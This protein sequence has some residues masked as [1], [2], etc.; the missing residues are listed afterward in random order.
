[1]A[2]LNTKIDEKVSRLD[3]N[4]DA[5]LR[6]LSSQSGPSVAEREAQLD[7]LL[8]L[9]LKHS[10]EEVEAKYDASVD[11]YLDTITQM[12]KVHDDLVAAINELIKHTHVRHEK[13]IQRLE[14][15]IKKKDEMN[16]I[17]QQVL[18]KLL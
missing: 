4:L 1:M 6:S 16:L 3:S 15:E 17:I 18:I 2:G 11:H 5:I 14:T 7:Q 10:I 13:Q 8:S 9:W 12:L